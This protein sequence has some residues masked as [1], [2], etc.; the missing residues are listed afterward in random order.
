MTAKTVTKTKIKEEVSPVNV[1]ETEGEILTPVPEAKGSPEEETPA[2]ATEPTAIDRD[3]FA[4]PAYIDPNARLP[5]LQALRGATAALCGYFIGAEQL[6]KAGWF[7]FAPIA[8]KIVTYTYESSGNE[9]QGLL[10]KS[11]RMLV[12]PRSG[13]L[14]YDRKGSNESGELM[15]VGHWRREFKDDENICNLQVYEVILLGD[16]NLPLH[17]VPFRYLAKGANGATF[18]QEWTKLCQEVT[19][20]HAIVNGIAAREKTDK[21]KSLCVFHFHTARETVGTKQK[22][23]ACRVTGHE[24]PTLENWRDFFIGYQPELKTLAW[25]TLQPETPKLSPGEGGLP[26][27]PASEDEE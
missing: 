25:E 9:E 16:D 5:R 21:F 26:A 6:A 13:L 8:D 27:L 15:L 18:S 11:P 4:D 7:D 23:A 22:S 10:L 12:C 17:A 3:E 2:G 1:P 19:T 24:V 14:G 20:C